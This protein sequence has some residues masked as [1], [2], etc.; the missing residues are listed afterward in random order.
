MA[1]HLLDHAQ[2]SDTRQLRSPAMA[3]AVGRDPHVK[4]SFAPVAL[5][6]ALNLTHGQSAVPAILQ[7]RAVWE[8][9]ETA[10]F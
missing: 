10:H 6:Q 3:K 2:G 9:L 8:S 5:H 1:E 4:A 7:E